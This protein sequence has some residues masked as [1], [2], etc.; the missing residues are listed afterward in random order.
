VSGRSTPATVA[1]QRAKVA[2]TVHEYEHDPRHPSYGLEAAEHLGV[3]AARIHK[4][5]VV[6]LDDGAGARARLGVA[7]VPVESKL[8]LKSCA[9]ALGA[10]R[11]EMADVSMAERTTGYV[12][13]GISPVGQKK[14][15]PTVI[16]A[17]AEGF[18][19]VFVSGGRR[20][21][22][23]ELAPADLLAVTNGVF[24]RVASR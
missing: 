22:D 18:A 5:L 20:G 9:A 17:D 10:K 3:D 7:V 24:A 16:D 23:I 14:S 19:T 12:A 21:L 15:L 13:G 11:A 2:H 6:S 1:L 4:T 8:D